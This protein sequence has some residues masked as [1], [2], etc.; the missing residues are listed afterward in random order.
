MNKAT[1]LNFTVFSLAVLYFPAP[2]PAVNPAVLDFV[3][4]STGADKNINYDSPIVDND[5]LVYDISY[6]IQKVEVQLGF[7]WV[8]V[9]SLL[10]DI[11]LSGVITDDDGLPAV[12]EFAD[13][14]V[15]GNYLGIDITIKADVKA[16]I[17]P[18]GKFHASVTNVELVGVT[19]FRVTGTVTAQGIT[20]PHLTTN[21]IGGNGSLSPADGDRSFGEKVELIASPDPGYHLKAWGG[22]DNDGLMELNNQVTMDNHKIATVEFEQDVVYAIGDINED[23]EVD[24]ADL[25]ILCQYWLEPVAPA[26]NGDLTGDGLVDLEDFTLFSQNWQN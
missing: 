18:D 16:W 14:E 9:T 11:P 3:F 15:V 20:K 2:S 5:Y 19:G 13:I 10:G 26:Q 1:L 7:F 25:K 24:I 8:N 4:Q 6:N 21:V 12:L 17:S 23:G 22:T